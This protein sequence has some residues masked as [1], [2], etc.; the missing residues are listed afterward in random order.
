MASKKIKMARKMMS[1]NEIRAVVPPFKSVAWRT[2]KVNRLMK[3]L[4]KTRW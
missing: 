2:R 4:Q 1:R 3:E